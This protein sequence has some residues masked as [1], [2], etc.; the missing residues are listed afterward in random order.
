MIVKNEKPV[1][2]R[3]LQSVKPLIDYWVIVD[4]G[5][6]DG[7][8]ETIR[9][10]MKEIPGELHEQS[11][12]NFGHNR[13]E[14]LKLAKGKGDYVLFIDADER[15]ELKAPLN[16][17]TLSLD[18]YLSSVQTSSDESLNFQR[19]LLI[20]NSLDWEWKGVLHEKLLCSKQTQYICLPDAK[21]YADTADGHRS[22]DPRKHFK[23]AELLEKAL[24]EDP[25]NS[26]YVYYLGQ[27]YFNAG[28]HSQSL[29]AYQKRA[30]MKGWD[31]HTFWSLYMVGMLQET[32]KYPQDTLIESYSKAYQFRPLRAEPLYRIASLF[33]EAGKPVLAY[34][35]AKT[36]L[37][38]PIPNDIVY[39]EKWIYEY[40]SLIQAIDASHLIG[41]KE[42]T[43]TLCK[44]LLLKPSLTEEHKKA[45]EGFLAKLD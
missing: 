17:N 25:E 5:S 43:K 6:T 39:V 10:F 20:D 7:T 35:V 2:E 24:L 36:A 8:Q 1:I 15:L 16:K 41:K 18:L 33:L 11:W 27:S 28:D 26:E 45:I 21:V 40:G 4:T 22:E 23:D 12:V 13:N 34:T 3:C 29:K 38:I 14:A 44:E 31:Q 30:T 32:L 37:S 9:E 19:T 42:E